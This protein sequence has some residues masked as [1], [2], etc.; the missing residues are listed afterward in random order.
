MSEPY[1]G[2]LISSDGTVCRI[3]L[4]GF[5]IDS[6]PDPPEPDEP[7]TVEQLVIDI[8]PGGIAETEEHSASD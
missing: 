1:L 5:P 7:S 2:I 4:D 6:P 3:G 8:E